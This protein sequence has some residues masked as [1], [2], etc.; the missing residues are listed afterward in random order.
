[1]RSCSSALMPTA[2]PTLCYV[3]VPFQSF[4]NCRMNRQ[5]R[6]HPVLNSIFAKHRL[7]SYIIFES[8]FFVAVYDDAKD[9]LNGIFMAVAWEYMKYINNLLW[10]IYNSHAMDNWDHFGNNNLADICITGECLWGYM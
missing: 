6:K 7:I 4:L 3:V 8:I 5:G 9:V 2:V 1:M 10:Y